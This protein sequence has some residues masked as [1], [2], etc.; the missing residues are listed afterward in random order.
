MLKHLLIITLTLVSSLQLKS[1]TECV[2]DTCFKVIIAL[3]QQGCAEFTP[4]F[5]TP[6]VGDACPFTAEIQAESMELIS[7]PF[8]STQIICCEMEGITTM[9]IRDTITGDSCLNI[10]QV[11]DPFMACDGTSSVTDKVDFDTYY[12][13][14]ML[15]DL[16]TASSKRVMISDLSGQSLY[17][18]KLSAQKDRLDLSFLP[19]GQIVIVRIS[20]IKGMKSLKIFTG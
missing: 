19:L 12:N 10:L 20:S 4:E 13:R 8:G 11:L 1:Q 5:A 7:V 18:Q 16:P 14:G 17:N 15:Y 2:L 3:G 6:G 9:A